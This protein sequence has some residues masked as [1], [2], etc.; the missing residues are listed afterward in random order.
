MPF[1]SRLYIVDPATGDLIPRNRKTLGQYLSKATSKSADIGSTTGGPDDYTYSPP[2]QNS[3][4]VS[5]NVSDE[6]VRGGVIF[7]ATRNEQAAFVQDQS[8]LQNFA[9]GRTLRNTDGAQGSDVHRTLPEIANSATTNPVAIEG[10]R[11]ITSVLSQNRFTSSRTTTPEGGDPAVPSV[12]NRRLVPDNPLRSAVLTVRGESPSLYEQMRREGIAGVLRSAGIEVENIA[13]VDRIDETAAFTTEGA[14]LA[15]RLVD[16]TDFRARRNIGNDRLAF[17]Q[18]AA[19]NLRNVADPNNNLSYGQ[20]NTQVSPFGTPAPTAMIVNAAIFAIAANIAIELVGGILS[21][22]LKETGR[23]TTG[24]RQRN[25]GDVIGRLGSSRSRPDDVYTFIAEALG[26]CLPYGKDNDFE[27]SGDDVNL[28]LSRARTGIRSVIGTGDSEDFAEQV[29]GAGFTVATSPGYYVVMSRNIVR[30]IDTLIPIDFFSSGGLGAGIEGVVS[31]LSAVKSSKIFRFVDTMARIG[32]ALEYKDRPFQSNLIDEMRPVPED[33]NVPPGDRIKKGRA[34]RGKREL[35]WSF[36]EAHKQGR[37]LLP[38]SFIT[39][40]SVWSGGKPVQRIG[41]LPITGSRISIEDSMLIEENL[42]AEY[43]PFYFKDLRTNEILNFHAFID[44]L[45]DS[46]SPSYTA[47][48]A[49]GRMDPVQIYKGTTRSISV[50]FMLVAT[51]PSDF[52][53]MWYSIN[54]LTM[55]VYPEWTRGNELNSSD[56]E[57]K[58]SFIQPFS[59]IPGS[60]PMVRLRIGDL[61]KSNYSRFGLARIFGLGEK[62]NAGNDMLTSTFTPAENMSPSRNSV[63]RSFESA[64]G[65]G[66]AGFITSLGYTWYDENTPWEVTAGSAAPMM[67]KVSIQFAPIHDIPLGLDHNGFMRAPAYPVGG[68]VNRVLSGSR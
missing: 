9:G 21:L 4:P 56:S 23:F 20:M 59:Q 50:G 67:C 54:R 52:D 22:V 40:S 41:N 13:N 55:M 63:V 53:A 37:L 25:L 39:G 7:D 30:N 64:E 19:E 18:P 1:D 58:L 34:Y 6:T 65:K 29:F 60:S 45:S 68:I 17:T 61:I 31:Y 32:I 57:E 33:S 11:R 15:A 14:A 46:Y 44:E 8:S 16:V 35:A 62:D 3:F 28:Y 48:E 27:P 36:S 5:P 49:Y 10:R 24:N 38:D 51:N 47:V 42:N 26:A 2:L 66:L 43:V 12:D